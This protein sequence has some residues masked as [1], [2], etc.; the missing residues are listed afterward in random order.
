VGTTIE[1]P[2]LDGKARVKIE[3]GTQPGKILRLRG[4][5]LPDINYGSRGDLLVYVN[6]WVPKVVGK[7]EI[8][9]IEQLNKIEKYKTI[10]F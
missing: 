2:T 4:K 6:V 8:G 3:A 1:V 10:V 9:L 7:D 5:G